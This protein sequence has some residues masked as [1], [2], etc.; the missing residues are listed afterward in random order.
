MLLLRHAVTPCRYDLGP[1]R[2]VT[3]AL[4]CTAFTSYLLLL[5]HFVANACV[6]WRGGHARAR[7]AA[8]VALHPHVCAAGAL[9]AVGLNVQRGIA[10]IA[11]AWVSTVTSSWLWCTASR[12]VLPSSRNMLMESGKRVAGHAPLRR[13]GVH[14]RRSICQRLQLLCCLSWSRIAPGLTGAQ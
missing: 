3:Y 12:P 4:Q 8:A 11:L 5:F 10:V 7:I 9:A 13:I 6:R 2:A 1:Q 14:I